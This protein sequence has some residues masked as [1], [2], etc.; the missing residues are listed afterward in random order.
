MKAYTPMRLSPLT[1]AEVDYLLYVL[2]DVQPS[3]AVRDLNCSTKGDV[4]EVL[5]DN[6]EMLKMTEPRR[7]GALAHDF[8][9]VLQ[10]AR[11]YGYP[12]THVHDSDLNYARVVATKASLKAQAPVVWGDEHK[13]QGADEPS[14]PLAIA[15]GSEDAASRGS[16]ARPNES[17]ER[18]N[19]PPRVDPTPKTFARQREKLQLESSSMQGHM[20]GSIAHKRAPA[21]EKSEDEDEDEETDGEHEDDQGR[22]EGDDKDNGGAAAAAPA[23]DNVPMMASLSSIFAASAAASSAR[24]GNKRTAK[25]GNTTV[26]ELSSDDADGAIPAPR[27][28]VKRRRQTSKTPAADE[29][30][31]AA[32][33]AAAEALQ[34]FQ[35]K[36]N[37]LG[38][39]QDE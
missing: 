9:N 5:K 32:R 35:G 26:E 27:S 1:D 7:S 38:A 11:E 18:R 14:R 25:R 23:G 6:F 17:G 10:V 36:A 8:S 13:R 12:L 22:E 3:M 31:E 33:V 19:Q 29:L 15:N 24:R 20:K 16:A 2:A 28:V 30:K 4:R 37:R 21:E 34:Y 39:D